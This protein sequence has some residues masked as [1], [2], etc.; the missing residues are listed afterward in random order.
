MKANPCFGDFMRGM[1]GFEQ[2]R[3]EYER[4]KTTL[5]S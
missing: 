3:I 5:N 1:P 4:R 2:A